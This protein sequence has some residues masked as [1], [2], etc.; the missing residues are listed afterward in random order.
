M[1]VFQYTLPSGQKIKINAETREKA[2][3]ALKQYQQGSSTVEEFKPSL[4]PAQWLND[5][6]NSALSGILKYGV[7]GLGS[8][9]GT[10]ERAS[11]Y[12]PGGQR[13]VG[14]DYS[15]LAPETFGKSETNKFLFPSYEQTLASLEKIPGVERFTQYQPKSRAGEYTETISGFVGPQGIVGAGPRIA[16]KLTGKGQ[17]LGIGET[18]KQ[19]LSGVAAGGTFEYLDEATNNTLLAAGVSLPVALTISALLSPSKAAKISANALKGVS[20]EEIA[21]AVNL[22]KYANKQGI[23]INA[24][25]LIN[26]KAINALGESVYGSRRGGNALNIALKDRPQSIDRVTQ[27]LLNKIIKD[28]GTIR[29]IN[30]T[31]QYNAVKAINEAK[32][33]RTKK[34][35]DAGYKVANEEFVPADQVRLIMDKINESIT[36]LPQGSP[37]VRLLNNLKKRLTVPVTPQERK[38]GLVDIPQTRINILD[39]TFKEFRENVSKSNIGTATTTTFVNSQGSRLLFNQGKGILDDLDALMKTNP[40]YKQA[41]K[42]YENLSKELVEFTTEN[43]DKLTKNVSQSTIKNFVFDAKNASPK[44]IQRTYE[45]FNKTDKTQF[46][47]LAR[48]YMENAINQAT[49]VTKGGTRSLGE[50]FDIA[51]TLVGS[52]KQKNNFYEM[53]RGVAKANDVKNTADFIKGFE[54]FNEI[55]LRTARLGNIDTPGGGLASEIFQKGIT[56]SVAQINSFMWRLK[57]ATRLGEYSERKTI[58]QLVNVLTKENSVKELVKLAKENPKSVTAINRV[59]NI[60]NLQMPLMRNEEGFPINEEGQ[61][62]PA[63]Q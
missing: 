9:P 25:E 16:S 24:V 56:K 59:R 33:T 4:T 41:N 51:K 63:L 21:V 28:P 20:K 13:T 53:L 55:L 27:V 34:S 3:S 43:L 44:D 14:I 38:L 1:T 6:Y 26:S 19:T 30:R 2:D 31:T 50:G 36:N 15:S 47:K 46:P 23:P 22:E 8:L 5:Q 12:L 18:A 42:M 40:S 60:I 35:Y 52:G 57:L 62:L 29:E 61:E 32:Q 49:V 11:T 48:I 54:N 17:T 10:L 37:N 58:D 7:A 45:L 39:D